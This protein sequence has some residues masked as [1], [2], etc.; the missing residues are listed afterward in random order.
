MIHRRAQRR[1]A[2]LAP[3]SH[4]LAPLVERFGLVA[5]GDGP[6]PFYDGAVGETAVVA[7][8]TGIGL[9]AAATATHRVLADGGVDRVVVVGI[10]GG[11]DPG[12]DIGAVVV[13]E[14][15]VD[16]DWRAFV[17]APLPGTAAHG[18]VRS[19]DEF[20]TDDAAI[21]RLRERGVI[22]LEMETAGVAPVCEARG[23]PWSVVRGISDRPADRLVDAAVWEM[24]G[25]DGSADPDGLRRYLAADAGAAAR[26]ARLAA[27]MARALTATTDAVARFLH[28]SG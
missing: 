23:V 21:V 5:R 26:L 24:T 19:S 11:I 9:A 8:M 25:P 20:L 22:A 28:L 6:D 7:V 17:P 4:E 16:D 15:V 13:P 3:M 1:V 10:A 27:D 2:L 18:L 12:L 14:A